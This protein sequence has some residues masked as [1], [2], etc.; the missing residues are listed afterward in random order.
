MSI[1]NCAGGCERGVVAK[2]MPSAGTAICANG[3]QP[4]PAVLA[5]L[6]LIRPQKR[7]T[8]NLA[9]QF[10]AGALSNGNAI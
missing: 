8:F 1:S 9:T 6:Q 4:M 5:R 10:A 3:L 2:W 7:A